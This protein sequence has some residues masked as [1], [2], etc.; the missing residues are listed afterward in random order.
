M[1]SGYVDDTGYIAEGST[2]TVEDDEGIKGSDDN[3][4][5]ESGDT[6]GGALENDSDADGNDTLVVTTYSHTSGTDV[7]GSSLEPIVIPVQ[8]DQAQFGIYGI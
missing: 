7:S 2:L 1:M 5:N 3:Y 4:N 6:S 8:L